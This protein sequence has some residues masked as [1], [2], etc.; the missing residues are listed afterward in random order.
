MVARQEELAAAAIFDVELDGTR[1]SR[2]T[3]QSAMLGPMSANQRFEQQQILSDLQAR[4]AAS[5]SAAVDDSAKKRKEPDPQP[6]A[7]AASLVAKAPEPKQAKLF[8]KAAAP[9]GK[10]GVKAS[11][12]AAAGDAADGVAAGAAAV[13]TDVVEVKLDDLT[14]TAQSFQALREA[15]EAEARNEVDEEIEA[16]LDAEKFNLGST[17]HNDQVSIN[18]Q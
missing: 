8:F 14:A 10:G 12:A 1:R 5:K 9:K 13:E 15:R 6:V 7:A 11:S 4:G 3:R 16:A 2:P 18:L 17:R